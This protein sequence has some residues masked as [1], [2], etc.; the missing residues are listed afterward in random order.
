MKPSTFIT[1]VSGAIASSRTAGLPAASDDIQDATIANGGP[2]PTGAKIPGSNSFSLCRG[3]RGQDL[4]LTVF[5]DVALNGA[6]VT[7][8]SVEVK[9]KFIGSV[10]YHHRFDVCRELS[11]VGTNCPLPPGP[12]YVNETFPV[13]KKIPH[14]TFSVNANAWAP[15]G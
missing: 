7:G 15:G 12:F 13:S 11:K 1:V 3:D 2:P 6:I 4:D 14:G 5:A 8:T 10:V 9:V